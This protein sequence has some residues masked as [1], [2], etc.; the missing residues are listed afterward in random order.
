MLAL[1]NDQ[2]D[3][4]LLDPNTDR[5]RLGTRYCAGGYIFQITDAKHGPLLTGPTWPH[6]F[7]TFDGQGIPDAFNLGP[8]RGPTAPFGVG[9]D[10]VAMTDAPDGEALVIGVG[11]CD[12]KRNQVTDWA[13][14]DV[15]TKPDSVSFFTLHTYQGWSIPLL[16]KV[17]LS[18]RTVRSSTT[19]RCDGM[20]PVHM[21]WFP[22]PFF[23]QMPDGSDDLIKL[24]IP[25]EIPD[26][27][28]GYTHELS[29]NWIS[30]KAWPWDGGRYQALRHDAHA[31]L[32]IQQR[33][34]KLGIVTATTSYIP[35]FFPI[36]GNPN[37]FS[38]EPFLER[39]IAQGQ[40]LTWWIDYDF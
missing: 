14:W 35:D 39:T 5:D 30:R 12:L 1:K 19:L 38:W 7:N 40:S 4:T 16:R 11:L 31:D 28:A 3:V 8:L 37:T 29:R 2:L 10:A 32:V 23:P 36:W 24:S 20:A 21:R 17:S 6:D 26:E 34:P 13:V 9:P 25:F 18:G 15:V 33:H 27:S 22:H